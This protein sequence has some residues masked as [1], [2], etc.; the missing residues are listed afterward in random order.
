MIERLQV[1]RLAVDISTPVRLSEERQNEL[2]ATVL[3]ALRL[4]GVSFWMEDD[5]NELIKIDYA[6][7]VDRVQRYQ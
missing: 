4:L 5:S 3:E 1:Y 7:T 2:A 6:K